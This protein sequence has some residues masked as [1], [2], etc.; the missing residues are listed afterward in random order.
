MKSRYLL[1][2]V[3]GVTAGFLIWLLSMPLIG[4]AEPWDGEGVGFVY[5]PLALLLA[6]VLSALPSPKYFVVGSLGVFLGQ[7]IQ[8]ILFQ[9]SGGLW[10]VGLVFILLYLLASLLGGGIV[11]LVFRHDHRL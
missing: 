3:I 11:Y 5:Y 8:I 4:Q 2:L 10:L 9:P 7:L 6:G 1:N